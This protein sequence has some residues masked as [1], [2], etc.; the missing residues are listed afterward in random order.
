MIERQQQP[1]WSG[2]PPAPPDFLPE[3]LADGP[4]DLTVSGIPLQRVVVDDEPTLFGLPGR[5]RRGRRG[6]AARRDCG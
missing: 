5:G 2:E 4:P 3:Q 6:T 1:T